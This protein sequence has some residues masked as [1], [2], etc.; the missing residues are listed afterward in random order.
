MKTLAIASVLALSLAAAGTTF[1]QTTPAPAPTAP[2]TPSATPAPVPA[3]TLDPA[4]EAKFKAGDKDNKG[5]IEGAALEPYKPMMDKIDTNKDGKIS[6][7]EF[8]A[9]AKAGIIK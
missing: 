6:K 4:M 2:A 8:A 1:A 7:A 3:V 9:A 5:F